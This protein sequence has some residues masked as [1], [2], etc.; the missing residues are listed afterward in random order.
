LLL[1]GDMVAVVE[2][3]PVNGIQEKVYTLVQQPSLT[4]DDVA[5]L[6]AEE[7]TH[8]FAT[9]TLLLLRDFA[10]YVT[11]AAEQGGVDM[12]AD[13]VGYREARLYATPEEWMAA[14][15]A[16]NQALLPLI[17]NEPAH[18]RRAYK[19]ATVVH[20]LTSE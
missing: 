16:V 11:V 6:S 3:R 9:Y 7:H 12:L 1:E 18:G 4:A 8:Y 15:G 14:M 17:V 2:T 10:A 5:G 19:F 13:Y 20:P